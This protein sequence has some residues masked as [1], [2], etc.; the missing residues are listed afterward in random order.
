VVVLEEGGEPREFLCEGVEVGAVA[1]GPEL[2]ENE[3]D[4]E[5]ERD[6]EQEDIQQRE[7]ALVRRARRGTKGNH[8]ESGFAKS[9]GPEQAPRWEMGERQPNGAGGER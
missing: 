8:Q 3:G 9:V 2:T 7:T 6:K 1:V 4:G 5:A